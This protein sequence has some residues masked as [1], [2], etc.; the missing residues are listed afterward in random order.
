M[1]P[2]SDSYIL[3]TKDKDKFPY[4]HPKTIFEN[5]EVNQANTLN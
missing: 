5:L 1:I 2:S 4:F 3:I